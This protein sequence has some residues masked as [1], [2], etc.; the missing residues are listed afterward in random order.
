MITL[1]RTILSPSQNAK[2]DDL[3][4]YLSGCENYVISD[5]KFVKPALE[6]YIKISM[7]GYLQ[8]KPYNYL[9]VQQNG[10]VYY[11]FIMRHK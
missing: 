11:Y 3:E 6:T 4:T 8:D 7:A 1:Y 2:Y 9:K 10:Y 5:F